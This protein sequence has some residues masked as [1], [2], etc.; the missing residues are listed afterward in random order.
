MTSLRDGTLLEETLTRTIISAFYDV[1][2]ALGFGYR[3]YIYALAL[4]RE[5]KRSGRRVDREVAVTVY[6][7]GEPLAA[8]VLDTIVD[9]KVVVET[10]ATENL[11]S[12]ATSQL[13]SY[14][15]AT[16]ME[17]GLLLHFGREKKF[18]RVFYE[19]RLKHHPSA[20]VRDPRL[21]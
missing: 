10:K 20:P 11:H 15:C 12:S 4:E 16:E 21:P 1:H 9:Q 13:F 3:E 14:L 2:R 6:Y 17:V 8:Q 18:H 19:N 5:L 7:R